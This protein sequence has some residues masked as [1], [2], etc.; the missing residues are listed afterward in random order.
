MELARRGLLFQR[1]AAIE[2]RYKGR[3]VGHGRVDLLVERQ[4]LVELKA[5]REFVPIHRAQV[6]SYLKAT[7]LTLGLLLNF[8]VRVLGTAGIMRVAND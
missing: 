1:Q 8:N 7:G 4:L 3:S 5:V 6:L 2:V